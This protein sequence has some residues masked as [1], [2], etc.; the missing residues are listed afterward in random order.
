M[1]MASVIV[2]L[3]VY[4]PDDARA[5]TTVNPVQ[6]TTFVLT[7]A[8]NPIIF[9]SGTNINTTAT[10]GANAVNG[11]AGTVWDGTQ[12]GSLLGAFQGIFLFETGSKL[13]NAGTIT[14]ATS[15]GVQLL[16]G[17]TVINQA[18][19]FIRGAGNGVK[20]DSATI[21]ND[22]SITGGPNGG[23]VGLTGSN[24]KVTNT[25]FITGGLFGVDIIGPSGT[26]ANSGSVSSIGPG[27]LS[28]V[29]EG[30]GTNTLILQTGTAL[31]GD[32]VGSAAAGA[33]NKL[34]L[35]GSGAVSTNFLSFNSLDVQASGTWVLDDNSDVGSATV[36]SGILVVG[37]GSLVPCSTA[38]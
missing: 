27:G 20:A 36:S 15:D 1:S 24:S 7:P 11:G 25:G 13:T 10:P 4:A 17:G 22:G 35:Q 31:R 38:T 34:N 29:F 18:T 19:G 21:T 5:Q 37:G 23:G 9:G 3:G 33:T 26:V 6:T 30:A 8:Q 32:A 12:L 2:T 14:G 16:N 28:V